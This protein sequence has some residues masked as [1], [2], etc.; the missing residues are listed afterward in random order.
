MGLPFYG[1]GWQ[2]VVDGGK[3]GEWQAAAGAAP[4]QFPEE[5]SSTSHR[6]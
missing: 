6:L 5:A 1:R 4:G 2:G 3:H